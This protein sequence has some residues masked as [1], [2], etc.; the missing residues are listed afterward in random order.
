MDESEDEEAVDQMLAD[1]EH[2][3]SPDPDGDYEGSQGNSGEGRQFEATD[4][5]DPTEYIPGQWG[6]EEPTTQDYAMAQGG[7]EEQEQERTFE[8][9]GW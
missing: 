6:S 5:R 2:I 8:E 7:N 1:T 9:N 3:V 4:T